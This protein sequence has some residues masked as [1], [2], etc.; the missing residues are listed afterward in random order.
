MLA[1]IFGIFIINGCNGDSKSS[2]S[3][4]PPVP[5]EAKIK[6]IQISDVG[7]TLSTLSG[8]EIPTGEKLQ[9]KAIGTYDNDTQKDLSKD[10][11][12][13]TSDEELG[14]FNSSTLETKKPG[15]IKVSAS[16]DSITSN[17]KEV[18]ISSIDL[19]SIN[20]SSNKS[21]TPLGVK[22]NFTASGKYSDG[23]SLD[24]T[25]TVSWESSD[26]TV[27]TISNGTFL[28]LTVGTTKI[29]ANV[30]NTNSA[31]IEI[32]VTPHILTSLELITSVNS[33]PL[34]T[35]SNITAKGIYSDNE[36]LEI[37]S[38]VKWSSSDESILTITNGK[39]STLKTGS[40]EITA[41]KDNISKSI[42]YEV[43]PHELVSISLSSSPNF[44]VGLDEKIHAVGLYTDDEEIPLINGVT[45]ESSDQTV[46]TIDNGILTPIKAGVTNITAI[47]DGKT[48]SLDNVKIAGLS[49]KF[50]CNGITGDF[51]CLP[52]K[53]TLSG[54]KYVAS[55]E[56]SFIERIGF[57][58]DTYAFTDKDDVP[59]GFVGALMTYEE[60]EQWC[61]NLNSV[62][63][64]G[65]TDWK[66]PENGLSNLTSEVGMELYTPL[67]WYSTS[68]DASRF[69]TGYWLN[70][71]G[72]DPTK[73]AVF[74]YIPSA[75]TA[76]PVDQDPTV[77]QL[78]I[79]VSG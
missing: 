47:K 37:T 24:M 50:P 56:K 22:L 65:I 5:K 66:L 20:I 26:K 69:F 68:N 39:I 54:K 1:V 44:L 71:P 70:Q 53:E 13:V 27:A 11:N 55:P 25:K 46:A 79:C 45:W 57:S 31:P 74:V 77:K 51:D 58:S 43:T 9:F 52:V 17:I 62:S 18:K 34:G 6:S 38:E 63:Y 67:G 30:S 29:T 3:P 14:T 33:L 2:N 19:I 75:G 59:L 4:V 28:P 23:N 60:A 12:W 72:V 15:I 76:F 10:V 73:K 78:T 35:S 8:I 32:E 49:E 42:T 21:K 61:Q 36:E 16:L 40:V 48:V 7:A 64:L 41:T